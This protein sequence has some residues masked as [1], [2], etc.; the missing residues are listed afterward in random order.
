MYGS[1]WNA[2]VEATLMIAPRSRARIPG[3]TAQVSSVSAAT[4]S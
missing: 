1:G 4:F 3:R 2:A